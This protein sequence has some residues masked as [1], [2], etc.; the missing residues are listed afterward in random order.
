MLGQI[1]AATDLKA[2]W[3]SLVGAPQ[4]AQQAVAATPS[5]IRQATM[6]PA[7]AESPLSQSLLQFERARVTYQEQRTLESGGTRSVVATLAYER[8]VL[9]QLSSDA[10]VPPQTQDTDGPTS[11]PADDC[12]GTF[13]IDRCTRTVGPA[14]RRDRAASHRHQ[15]DHAHVPA[16]IGSC[17]GRVARCGERADRI[18]GSRKQRLHRNRTIIRPSNESI[19]MRSARCVRAASTAAVKRH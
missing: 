2:Q 5:V 12:R 18:A 9:S 11:V 14:E 10:T 3:Q 1:Q 7:S 8:V 17:H 13:A 4:P 15:C 16:A 19:A 6:P